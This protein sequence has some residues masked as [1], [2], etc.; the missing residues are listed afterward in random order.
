MLRH[1]GLVRKTSSLLSSGREVSP[2]GLANARGCPHRAVLPRRNAHPP[3]SSISRSE[4]QL[5]QASADFYRRGTNLKSGGKLAEVSGY[6]I[7]TGTAADVGL[8]T[9]DLAGN[10]SRESER[11]L[12]Y[13]VAAA[14]VH[15]RMLP[16]EPILLR[17]SR[18]PTRISPWPLAARR[19]PSP[20]SRHPWIPRWY[21]P[22]S[23]GFRR[24]A[25]SGTRRRNRG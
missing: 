9:I 2:G 21:S 16:P 1:S 3:R 24:R 4:P 6:E 10:E 20:S 19:R 18:E 7:G 14:A 5:N 17:R 8:E 12:F 11:S 15:F 13:R 23:E 25:R 22:S